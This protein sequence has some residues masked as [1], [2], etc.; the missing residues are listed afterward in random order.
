MRLGVA[1]SE[2]S[3]GYVYLELRGTLR[4]GDTWLWLLTVYLASWGILVNIISGNLRNYLSLCRRRLWEYMRG[5]DGAFPWAWLVVDL[6][7]RSMPSYALSSDIARCQ[8]LDV[9]ALSGRG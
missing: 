1:I 3:R 2:M 7:D 8:S 4:Y 5:L 9:L 6:S